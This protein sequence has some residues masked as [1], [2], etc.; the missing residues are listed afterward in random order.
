MYN[1]LTKNI[2]TVLSYCRII[3]SGF[4]NIEMSYIH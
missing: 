4:K 2:I 1:Y 3:I